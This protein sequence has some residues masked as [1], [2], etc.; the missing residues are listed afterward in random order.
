M[1]RLLCSL[2]AVLLAGSTIACLGQGPSPEKVFDVITIKKSGGFEGGMGLGASTPDTISLSNT[3]I[4]SL[5]AH[6]YGIK[7]DAIVGAPS[8]VGTEEF[9]INAKVLPDANGVVPRL[10]QQEIEA[11]FKTLLR[12][13]FQLAAHFETRR[14]PV[15]ELS[16]AGTGSKL[17]AASPGDNYASGIKMPNGRTG[18]GLRIV[19][20][21]RFTGQA[22][23][24]RTLADTLSDILERTVLDQTNLAGLYD[25]SFPIPFGEKPTG[26]D[27]ADG[28]GGETEQQPSLASVLSDE[29]GLRLKPAK[30]DG[31]VL[32]IDKINEP[33]PN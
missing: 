6:A 27:A 14:I 13:R 21:H 2:I 26:G 33:S 17:K 25:V 4:K 19:D 8:W 12:D 31:K 28:H 23:T 29:L 30:A 24:T 10:N 18:A 15:Y 32:V 11:R 3:P 22:I 9:D 20:N 16:V 5:I 1:N 7:Q